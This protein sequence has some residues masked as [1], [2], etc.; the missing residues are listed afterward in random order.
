MFEGMHV[1]LQCFFDTAYI[2]HLVRL[3]QV[4]VAVF[5]RMNLAKHQDKAAAAQHFARVLH[6]SWGVGNPDCQNGALLLLA[7]GDRQVG[8][9]GRWQRL[10]GLVSAVW[11]LVVLSTV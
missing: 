11:V 7:V 9:V 2:C 6:D 4:A 8:T 10:L 3:T 1:V 5:H